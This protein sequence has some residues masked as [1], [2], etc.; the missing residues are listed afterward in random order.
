MGKQRV[1]KPD[2]LPSQMRGRKKKK[3]RK[4][5]RRLTQYADNEKLKGAKLA[6]KGETSPKARAKKGFS[7]DEMLKRIL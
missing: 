4:P 7:S 3:K 1:N 5:K 6:R 2:H